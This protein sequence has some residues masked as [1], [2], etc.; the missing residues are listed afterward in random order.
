MMESVLLEEVKKTDEGEVRREHDGEKCEKDRE[1][2]MWREEG[3]EDDGENEWD[4][5]RENDE[6][7]EKKR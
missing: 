4:R 2:I 3:T 6:E 7:R 5:L 1:G